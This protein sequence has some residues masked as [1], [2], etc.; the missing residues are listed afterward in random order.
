MKNNIISRYGVPQAII[1]NNG[2]P[3]INKRMSDFLDK[4]KI[5]R[6]RLS[7][8][9]PQMNGGVEAANKTIICILEKMVKTYR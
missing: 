8:Y 6:H 7:P 3:F 5:Q 4:F 1:T 2:T 9:R